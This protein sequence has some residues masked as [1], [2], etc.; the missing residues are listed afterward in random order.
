MRTFD[1]GHL[2]KGLFS[3]MVGDANMK[4]FEDKGKLDLYEQ[5]HPELLAPFEEAARMDN[6]DASARIEGLYVDKA[7]V[8]ALMAEDEPIGETEAQI[9]GYAKALSVIDDELADL[10]LSTAT[11]VKLFETMYGYRNLGRKS[12]YRKKDYIYSRRR[13]CWAAHATAWRKRSAQPMR[14]RSCLQ[15]FSRSISSA[16]ARSMRGTGAL[17]ACSP[18]SC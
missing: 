12:R 8:A 9:A 4:V 6:A 14:V 18:I 5:M 17:R 1:Y 7:R 10:D 13:S 11:I 3:G 16:F 15:R 2:P